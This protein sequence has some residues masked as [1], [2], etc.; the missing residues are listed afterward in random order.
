MIAMTS[1]AVISLRKK[2]SHTQL[3]K[4]VRVMSVEKSCSTTHRTINNL[5]IDEATM[6]DWIHILPLLR[7][8]INKIFIYGDRL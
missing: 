5:H 1:Q 4:S 7:V 2:I 3:G 6:I 8:K